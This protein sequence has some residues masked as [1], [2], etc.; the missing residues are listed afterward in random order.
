[1]EVTG[2]CHCGQI[3]YRAK[4]DPEKISLCHCTDCQVMGGSAYRVSAH[5]PL[6]DFELLSGK[7]KIYVKAA[8]SGAKRVQA[9][10]PECGTPLYAEAVENPIIRS[11]RVGHGAT[12]NPSPKTA[13]LVPIGFAM[14]GRYL[15]DRAKIRASGVEPDPKKPVEVNFP[16]SFRSEV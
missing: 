16:L 8:D 15:R 6:K 1:M 11:L 13:D 9:F 5:I 7:V 2:K 12:N 3:R 4:I 10:C 14:V